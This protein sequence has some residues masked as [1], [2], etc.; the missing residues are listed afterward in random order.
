MFLSETTTCRPLPF[1]TRV[2]E[3]AGLRTV[4]PSSCR[5]SCAA[6]SRPEESVSDSTQT[7]LSGR[8]LA[9]RFLNSTLFVSDPFS[10]V[11][12]NSLV[13]AVPSAVRIPSPVVASTS[14][15][16]RV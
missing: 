6:I 9:D 15:A 7:T 3:M 10:A 16:C 1:V 13:R 8:S 5:L 4:C 14:F 11:N 12:L 2:V